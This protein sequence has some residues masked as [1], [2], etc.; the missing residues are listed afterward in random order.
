MSWP[1]TGIACLR[2][3]RLGKK[4]FHIL[5]LLAI[6][7][8]MAAMTWLIWDI[9]RWNPDRKVQSAPLPKSDWTDPLVTRITPGM[10]WLER[11][12]G[13]PAIKKDVALGMDRGQLDALPTSPISLLLIGVLYHDNPARSLAAFLDPF[14]QERV[15]KIG[16]LLPEGSRLVAILRDRVIL[17]RNGIREQLRLPDEGQ[18]EILARFRARVEQQREVSRVWQTFAEKPEEVLRMVRLN[19]AEQNGKLIGVRLDHG[20]DQ[21]FLGRFGLQSGDIVTWLNG[22]KLDSYEKGMQSLRKLNTAQTMR[23]KVLRGQETLEFTYNR[24]SGDEKL[25]GAAMGWKGGQQEKP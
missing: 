11:L 5:L 14:G 21:G 19:P 8:E 3:P 23:F 13:E 2:R 25:D 9:S 18:R 24:S 4:I 1:H 12:F 17:L 10:D 6:S 20:Q 22:E 15:R 7:R 16:A